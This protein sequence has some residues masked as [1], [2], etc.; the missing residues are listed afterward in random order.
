MKSEK[1]IEAYDSI[2]YVAF[3]QSD[4]DVKNHIHERIMQKQAK[5]RPRK[6]I[7]SIAAAIVVLLAASTAAFG[8]MDW[9]TQRYNQPHA[10]IA[11]QPNQENS[12]Q[13][14]FAI[15][16]RLSD[17]DSH[18]ISEVP[19][20]ALVPPSPAER[21]QGIENV[22]LNPL[23]DPVDSQSTVVECNIVDVIFVCNEHASNLPFRDLV[24]GTPGFFT[25]PIPDTANL[26]SSVS[27][28]GWRDLHGNLWQAGT[29]IGWDVEV[30][31]TLT[32][33]A[34]WS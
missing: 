1:I 14:D 20:A 9:F 5:K 6:R 21:W 11:G 31:G 24:I 10:N 2:V 29:L 27:F 13:G 26:G 16:A 12:L 8:G 32:L 7:I 15:D 18:V 34:E 30:S 23:L 4:I 19:P 22:A 17:V 33:T 25:I 3:G 28:I